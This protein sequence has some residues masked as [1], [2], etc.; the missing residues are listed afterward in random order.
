MV[1][2]REEIQDLQD[3]LL[4]A[5]LCKEIIEKKLSYS[6]APEER[7]V[8]SDRIEILEISIAWINKTIE[9]Y[10]NLIKN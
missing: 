1:N 9:K 4:D 5:M 3:S 2:L 7:M 10:E 8:W 6:T